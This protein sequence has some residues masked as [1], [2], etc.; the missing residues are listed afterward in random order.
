MRV[1]LFGYSGR[2]ALRIYSAREFVSVSRKIDRA[3]A[4]A[5]AFRFQQEALLHS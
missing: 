4:K 5:H 1:L 3:A 2:F